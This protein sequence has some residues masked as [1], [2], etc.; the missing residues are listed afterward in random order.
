MH[1]ETPTDVQTSTGTTTPEDQ[2][3]SESTQLRSP[4]RVHFRAA[5][6]SS[7]DSEFSSKGNAQRTRP[8][9]LRPSARAARTASGLVSMSDA[10]LIASHADD[11]GME[12]RAPTMTTG[13]TQRT[14]TFDELTKIQPSDPRNMIESLIIESGQM[15]VDLSDIKQQLNWTEVFEEFYG[16]LDEFLLSYQSIF[17]VSPVADSVALRNQGLDVTTRRSTKPKKRQQLSHSIGSVSYSSIAE[18]FN[19]DGLEPLYRNRGYRVQRIGEEVLHVSSHGILDL[20]ILFNGVVVWW[21][22]D[23]TDHWVVDDDFFEDSSLV[24]SRFA[25]ERH[26]Q[27]DIWELFPNWCTYEFDKHSVVDIPSQHVE[28]QETLNRFSEKLCFDHYLIPIDEPL[29]TQVMVVVSFSLARAAKVDYLEHVTSA[30]QRA[31]LAIPVEP[32]SLI[33]HFSARKR[34]AQLE[35]ELRVTQMTITSLHETPDI[36]WEMPWL[37]GYFVLAENQTSVQPRREWFMARSDALFQKLQS[38]QGRRHR[39]FMMS[40]DVFLIVLLVLD[41][42][43]MLM[44]LSVKMFFPKDSDE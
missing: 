25:N 19:L 37:R 29:R 13:D 42:V 44:R 12:E 17:V 18:S 36:L 43:A 30:T 34:I 4:S 39:L 15:S 31:V 33:D 2:N 24:C 23:R 38:I 32:K 28:S 27:K 8:A 21:G 20:F 16:S 7:D 1:S 9:S 5:S 41:V 35:G 26:W 14:S 22:M 11:V 3:E 10:P 40:S 6:T